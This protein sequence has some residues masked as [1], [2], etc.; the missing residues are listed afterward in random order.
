MGTKGEMVTIVMLVSHL[1]VTVNGSNLIHSQLKKIRSISFSMMIMLFND[2]VYRCMFPS[3]PFHLKYHHL[4]QRCKDLRI[5]LNY[6][7]A[8]LPP[9]DKCS[10]LPILYLIIIL[11]AVLKLNDS[12]TPCLAFLRRAFLIIRGIVVVGF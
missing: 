1:V 5:P 6:S 7:A 12:L 9:L 4:W 11:V 8:L 3:L 2:Y 10:L